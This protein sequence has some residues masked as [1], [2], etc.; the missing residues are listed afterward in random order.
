[1]WCYNVSLDS[2]LPQDNGDV[3]TV[4]AKKHE[5]PRPPRTFDDV[6]KYFEEFSA[7]IEEG[8]LLAVNIATEIAFKVCK[9]EVWKTHEAAKEIEKIIANF[10]GGVLT[11]PERRP[12]T[13]TLPS[14]PRS[15]KRLLPHVDDFI[16]NV[17]R[18][19]LEK[20]DLYFPDSPL[21]LSLKSLIP[22]NRELNVGSFPPRLLFAGF[23]DTIPE[24]RKGMGSASRLIEVF[25]HLQDG[26]N[27]DS[28]K[29]RFKYMVD[30]VYDDIHFIVII[31]YPMPNPKLVIYLIKSDDFRNLLKSKIDEGPE[32]LTE[33]LYRFELHSMRLRRDR[34]LEVAD[35]IEIDVIDYKMSPI[36]RFI[37]KVNRIYHRKLLTAKISIDEFKEIMKQITEEFTTE[38]EKRFK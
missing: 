17:S 20:T 21:R 26:G 7:A 33:V 34:V 35:K 30:A 13:P 23:L 9:K 1:M 18:A 38:V 31:R 10:L 14:L 29:E 8:D 2:F 16:N 12:S 15:V 37:D 25:K 24:E 32:A 6:K 19:A 22:E 3:Y 28:F 4:F 36:F 27:W 11:S 5:L